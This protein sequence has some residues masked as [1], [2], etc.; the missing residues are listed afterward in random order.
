MRPGFVIIV[1]AALS[2]AEAQAQVISPVMSSVIDDVEVT[3]YR[4]PEHYGDSP[5]LAMIVEERSVD[6]PGGPATIQF[7][8]VAD[9]IIPQTAKVEGLP[10]PPIESNFDYDLL[11]PAALTT[12]SIG[13]SVRIVRT[14]R[15]NGSAIEQRGILRS[16]PQGIVL[17]VD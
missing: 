6:F 14:N 15:N 16:G 9:A 17:D 2:A 8:G 13:S 3:I 1:C 4:G 12:K 10:T 7:Q 11:S 5:G